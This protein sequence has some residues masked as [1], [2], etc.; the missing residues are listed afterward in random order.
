[1][2]LIGDTSLP[3]EISL[4]IGGVSIDRKDRFAKMK[5]D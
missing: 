2:L 3:R 5:K 4:V 1:M